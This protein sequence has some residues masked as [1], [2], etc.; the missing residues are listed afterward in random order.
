MV[1][2]RPGKCP[3]FLGLIRPT[4]EIIFIETNE[5]YSVTPSLELQKAVEEQFGRESY[6]AK[7]DTALPERAPRQWE[8]RSDN[9]NGE[10]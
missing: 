9:G 10:G 7:V 6:Y 4:G 5:R 2:T 3:L 1:Q 8:R